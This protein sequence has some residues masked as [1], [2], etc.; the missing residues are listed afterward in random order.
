[1]P[2]ALEHVPLKYKTYELCKLA[3]DTEIKNWYGRTSVLKTMVPNRFK[4][5]IKNELNI[6]ESLDL[7]YFQNL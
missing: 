3:V 4:E 2:T 5:R 6:Q 7:Q 1:M